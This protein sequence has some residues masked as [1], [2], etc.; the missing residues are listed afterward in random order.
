MLTTLTVIRIRHQRHDPPEEPDDANRCVRCGFA[1]HQSSQPSW[2]VLY[3]ARRPAN[4]HG[5]SPA[6]QGNSRRPMNLSEVD[7]H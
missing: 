3:A 4:R 6:L 1:S 5:G 7:V 2:R